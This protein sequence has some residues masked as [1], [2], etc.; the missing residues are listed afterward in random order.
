MTYKNTIISLIII[1]LLAAL[2]TWTTL[3]YRPRATITTQSSSLPDAFMEDV[4]AIIMNKQGKINMKIVTPKMVHYKEGDT[5]QLTTPE[6]T[7]YRKSPKP[8][9]ITSKYATATQGI[10]SVLFWENVNIHH[11]ADQDNPATL[12]ETPKLLVHPNEQTAETTEFITLTQ[13]NIV[14]KATGMFADMNTGNIKLL[15]QA[16]GEYVPSS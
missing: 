14:V 7:L 11:P 16:R 4:T 2:T 5:T 10:D 1:S 12:I 13:P 9:F 8:W 3:F 6:L 15:S